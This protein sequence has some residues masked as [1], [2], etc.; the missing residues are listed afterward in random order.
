MNYSR[1]RFLS[2]SAAAAAGFAG[3]N[4]FA[5]WAYGSESPGDGLGPLLADPKGILDLPNGF[6]YQVLSTAGDR[7]DDGFLVPLLPDAMATFGDGKGK[8][9]LLRNHEMG[10]GSWRGD[11]DEEQAK[12]LGALPEHLTYDA[13][14]D[15]GHCMGGVST[16]VYDTRS[17]LVESEFLSL[18][19]TVRNCAGGLTPWNTWIT[20]E[21][22]TQSADD[23]FSK[24]H[25]FNFEVT[26]S[27]K[28]Q[29]QEPVRLPDM[30]RFNH[31]AV[32]VDPASGIVYETEDAGDSLI[33]RYLPNKP[34]HLVEG[35]RLQ[36]LALREQASCDTRNWLED[37]MDPEDPAARPKTEIETG[38]RF[39]VRW[40]DMQ[41]ID[42]PSGDL[43]LRGFDRGAA[44][45]ARGEGM[46][47]GEGSVFFVCTS[48]GR[49]HQGQ[50][51][52]YTPSPV[53]GTDGELAKPGQL[54]LYCEP[55]ERGLIENADNLTVAPWGD[56]IVCEDGGGVDFLVGITP[57]GQLYRLARNA[58]SEAE[59]AGAT[60]SPDGSTLF[61]NIQGDGLTLAITGP[62]PTRAS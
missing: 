48:G 41:E 12:L 56:V 26:A 51:W 38:T 47:Y 22:T 14:R 42:S 32:A 43:R 11:F 3:L 52:R 37:G 61:V 28:Q 33:Y 19:G 7:M 23:V 16:I 40:I 31:E 1:R 57:D 50:I 46:W 4:Q 30:G 45:F 9:I 53:E 5:T 6:S 34:G 20:C 29:L 8:T 58:L 10:Y 25:G 15:D 59:L 27:A 60:F 55:K 35:G 2:T 62:W 39:D 49:W 18:V 36:A 54:E 44:R 13:T 21:E 17:G 24:D